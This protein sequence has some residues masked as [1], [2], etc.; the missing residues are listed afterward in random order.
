MADRTFSART[1]CSRRRA[2]GYPVKTDIG[3]HV[4]VVRDIDAPTDRGG[5]E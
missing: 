3:S 4:Q 1:T 5:E 2:S